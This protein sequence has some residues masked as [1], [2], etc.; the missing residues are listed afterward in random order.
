MTDFASMP[1]ESRTS[2]PLD[3]KRLLM[4]QGHPP[5]ARQ[6]VSKR[7]PEQ[8]T[9]QW[10]TAQLS[11]RAFLTSYLSDRSVVDDCIQEVALLAWKKGPEDGPP[12]AFL[13]FC[14]ACAKRI[15]MGEVRKKYRNKLRLLDPEI[16]TSLADTVASLEHQ[17]PAPPIERISA[18]RG[19]LEKLGPD[20]RRLLEIRYSAKDPSALKREAQSGKK[21]MDAI[22]KTLERLRAKLRDCVDSKSSQPE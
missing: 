7:E 21:S 10:A 13:G 19:C 14:I 18:L 12:E 11:V 6:V 9:A 4:Q 8:F 3:D 15:A 17:E 1:F 22:Y 2:Y 16:V 20:S 5:N